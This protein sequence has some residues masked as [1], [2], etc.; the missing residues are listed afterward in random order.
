MW[1]LMDGSPSEQ[2][3]AL[4]FCLLVWNIDRQPLLLGLRLWLS[5]ITSVLGYNSPASFWAGAGVFPSMIATAEAGLLSGNLNPITIIQKLS[6][7]FT[8]YPYIYGNLYFKFPKPE[9]VLSL[10]SPWW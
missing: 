4:L 9:I 3:G 8:I 6:R 10:I 7:L 5:V 2:R 1:G